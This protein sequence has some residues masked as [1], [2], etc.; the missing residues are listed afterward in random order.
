MA[1]VEI[2]VLVAT[3][4]HISYGI[5]C[6]TSFG[7][8][9]NDFPVSIMRKYVIFGGIIEKSLVLERSFVNR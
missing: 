7:K 5:Y 4:F 9:F 2:L 1:I 3:D 6:I 8:W